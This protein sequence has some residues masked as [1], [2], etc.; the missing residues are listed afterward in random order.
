M[1]Y[2]NIMFVCILMLAL[3]SASAAPIAASDALATWVKT[4]SPYGYNTNSWTT[5]GTNLYYSSNTGQSLVTPF[6]HSYDFA[7]SVRM[8]SG[9]TDNDRYG[10]LFG[11]SDYLNHYRLSWEGGGYAEDGGYRGLQLIREVNGV[12]VVLDTLASYWAANVV[13]TFN[14][15]R[16][17]NTIGYSVVRV[18][19]N[20]TIRSFS[21]VDT[22][23]MS[24]QIGI[25][26]DSQIT[27][28]SNMD[29]VVPEP[30]SM[31]MALMGLVLLLSWRR[32]K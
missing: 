23:I 27:Y 2:K 28:Y 13:Y 6:S 24:G 9:D 30:S 20:V 22:T 26:N 7:F 8:W 17:G 12:A 5:S 19:D 11:F 15:Y 21:V 29:L 4:T 25:F 32:N 3:T 16:T 18:S 1:T 10:V 31:L 14:V